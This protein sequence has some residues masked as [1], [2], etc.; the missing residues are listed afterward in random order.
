MSTPKLS[1]AGYYDTASDDSDDDDDIEIARYDD[2]IAHWGGT[3]ELEK[4]WL[5]M[6]HSDR[7][8]QLFGGLPTRRMPDGDFKLQYNPTDKMLLAKAKV[9]VTHSL[10]QARKLLKLADNQEINPAAAFSAVIPCKFIESFHAYLEAPLKIGATPSWTFS[11]IVAF[12]RCKVLMR[13]YSASATELAD[14]DVPHETIE[15]FTTVRKA[16]TNADLPHSKRPIVGAET[17][18]PACTFDPILDD[19]VKACCRQWTQM[20]FVAGNSW[21]DLDDDKIPNSS[22]LWK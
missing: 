2:L 22:P 6:S 11:D 13:L 3:V 4:D 18:P 17:K 15:Q 20:F 10:S 5:Y 12:L 19:A 14:F 1:F 9:E 21:V 16:L 7:S 8:R